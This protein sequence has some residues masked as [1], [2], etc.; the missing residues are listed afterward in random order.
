LF[1]IT[2]DLNIVEAMIFA[3]AVS[4]LMQGFA[5]IWF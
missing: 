5:F 4:V 1:F 2:K 3:V